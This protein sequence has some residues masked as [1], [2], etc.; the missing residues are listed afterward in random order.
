MSSFSH[1]HT[2]PNTKA[3]LKQPE[4]KLHFILTNRLY[5]SDMQINMIYMIILHLHTSTYF[6]HR[7]AKAKYAE[8]LLL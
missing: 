6:I 3:A 5:N 7:D 2:K 1:A 8:D 4:S